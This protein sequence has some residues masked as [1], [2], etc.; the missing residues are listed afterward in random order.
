MRDLKLEGYFI[1]CILN[2]TYFII[3]YCIACI[4]ESGSSR[5]FVKLYEVELY[6]SHTFL[7]QGLIL[8]EGKDLE[9]D[10]DK[11]K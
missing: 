7:N 11:I 10:F 3:S 6:L 1:E 4:M 9:V 5:V 8:V 2:I